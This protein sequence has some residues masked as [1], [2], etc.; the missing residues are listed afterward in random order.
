MRG[1]QESNVLH[2]SWNMVDAMKQYQLLTL[3]VSSLYKFEL[4]PISELSAKCMEAVR[5]IRDQETVEVADRE[6]KGYSRVISPLISSSTKFDLN[7]M[8]D[9]FANEWKLLDQSWLGKQEFSG[10]WQRVNQAWGVP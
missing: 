10:M 2:V 8:S 7:S 6:T 3:S 5:L 9:L 1:L 4:N